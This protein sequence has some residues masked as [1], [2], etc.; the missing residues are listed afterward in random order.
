VQKQAES[1]RQEAEERR[2]VRVADE[3]AARLA[4]VALRRLGGPSDERDEAFLP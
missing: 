2:F 4:V 3:T 1:V